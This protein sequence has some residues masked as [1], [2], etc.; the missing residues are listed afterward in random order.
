[1]LLITLYNIH[2]HVYNFVEYDFYPKIE[3]TRHF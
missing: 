2:V 3:K 1:M